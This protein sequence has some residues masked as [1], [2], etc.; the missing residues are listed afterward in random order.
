MMEPTRPVLRW[1]G[2]KWRLAPWI[3]GHFPPHRVY[4]EPF[5]GAAS[6]LIRKPRSYAEVYN[7]LDS[8]VVDLFRVLRDPVRAA[9]LEQLL[10]RTPFAR[11][12]FRAAY[13]PTDDVIERCRRLIVRSF[14]GFGSNA[15]ASAEKGHRSTGFRASSSRSGTTPAADWANYPGALEALIRRVAGVVIEQRPA[16]E[17]MAQHDGRTTLHYVDPPYLHETRAQG[18]KY[19][20]G[21]RMYRYEMTNAEHLD[22]LDFLRNCAGMVVLSGYAAPLYDEHL[23]DWMRVEKATFADGAR[24]RTEVLWINPAAAEALERSQGRQIALFAEAA[25]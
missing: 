24:E 12:E 6:V 5:G 1:H 8:E 16:I 11:E 17:V 3:I 13:E 21:W 10:R 23:G 7:D 4:V 22:L 25:E 20:L 19:D 14:M 9:A 18:N 2:G 15:H